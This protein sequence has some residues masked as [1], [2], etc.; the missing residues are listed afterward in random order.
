MKK[1]GKLIKFLAF[2]GLVFAVIKA[3]KEG[4]SIKKVMN[5]YEKNI[6]F[7]SEALNYEDEV[8]EN[9]SVALLCSS[10]EMD[11]QEAKLDRNNG[12]LDIFGRFSAISVKLPETWKVKLSGIADNSAVANQ[13]EEAEGVEEG[14]VLNIQYDLKMSALSI[15]NNS[16][17]SEIEEEVEEIMAEIN[18]EV[19]EELEEEIEETSIEDVEEILE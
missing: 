10:A 19:E 3:I 4:R 13:V 18:E 1:I 14:P 8:I 5:T 12:I 6:K 16:E 2:V 15:K 11:F 17:E 7:K 9:K